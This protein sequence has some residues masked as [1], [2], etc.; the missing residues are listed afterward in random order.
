MDYPYYLVNGRTSDDPSVCTAQP[1]DRIRPR[2]IKCRAGWAGRLGERVRIM[3][4]NA[5][6][7][8]HPIHLHGHTFA[9]TKVAR[10]AR[11]DTAILLPNRKL[12]VDLDVDNPG[13]WMTHCHDVYHAETGMMTVLGHRR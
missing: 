7:T 10:G 8:W 13:L 12:T 2:I 3:F 6:K 1:G 5:T 4:I 9:L 11:K